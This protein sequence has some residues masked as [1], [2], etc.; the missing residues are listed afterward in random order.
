MSKLNR[1]KD[2]SEDWNNEDIEEAKEEAAGETAEDAASEEE[3]KEDSKT[4]KAKKEDKASQMEQK[5]NEA[6]DRLLRLRA[7]YDNFR[8]RS[9]KEKD[10]MFA[11]GAMS[12]IA[13]ILPVVDNLERALEAARQNPESGAEGLLKG[14]EMTYQQFCDI[15]GKLGVTVI[16]ASGEAFDP[17]LHN[18]VMHIEDEEVGENTVVEEFQKG[19]L[20]KDKVVRHAIVK[21][22]N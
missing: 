12:V 9:Q 1:K 4:A 6:E 10:G 5:L 14:V 20:Y 17:T 22:A 16:A 7:E 11:D 2:Q 8:K 3:G 21:V 15:L 18:A 13:A 19:Y